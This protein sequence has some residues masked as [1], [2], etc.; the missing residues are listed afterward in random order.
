MVGG[1]HRRSFL[2]GVIVPLALL[3]G[4]LSTVVH[5]MAVEHERCLEHGEL[6]HRVKAPSSAR[7][8][9]ARASLGAMAASDGHGDDHCLSLASRRETLRAPDR[10]TA[11]L[12]ARPV[13]SLS[14]PAARVLVENGALLRFAPKTSPPA[15]AA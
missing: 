2:L 4:Q 6:V 3:A 1:L 13:A 11:A 12:V 7:A 9:A 5:S 10:P 8:N 14:V 15:P